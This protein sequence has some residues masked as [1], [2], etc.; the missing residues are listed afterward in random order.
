[1][2]TT[3]LELPLSTERGGKP[4]TVTLSDSTFYDNCLFLSP[5]L[6]ATTS[7]CDKIQTLLDLARTQLAST[8][9]KLVQRFLDSNPGL[10]CYPDNHATL[11]DAF[12]SWGTWYIPDKGEPKFAM[13]CSHTNTINVKPSLYPISEL[14]TNEYNSI[15][16]IQ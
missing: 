15:T 13:L 5:A 7:D 4:M 2:P 14:V 16:R 12:T 8:P 10:Y 1:M 11:L 9:K 3:H 6:L